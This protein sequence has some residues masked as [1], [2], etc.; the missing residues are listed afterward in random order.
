MCQRNSLHSCAVT[1]WS[2]NPTKR[3]GLPRLWGWK[4]FSWATSLF[5]LLRGRECDAHPVTPCMLR[6]S[7]DTTASQDRVSK[8]VAV[9]SWHGRK[10]EGRMFLFTV[11]ATVT[12]SSRVIVV[13]I[14]K[15]KNSLQHIHTLQGTPGQKRIIYSDIKRLHPVS[16][17]KNK[18]QQI[19]ILNTW[20][21]GSDLI[22]HWLFTF[23]SISF[24]NEITA[25]TFNLTVGWLYQRQRR[26]QRSA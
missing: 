1:I 5:L 17:V 15:K 2:Q 25:L 9:Q 14:K 4:M 22:S 6:L 19:F 21:D 13:A 12:C 7:Q 24:G 3:K 20:S 8:M 26:M 18:T 23:D 16:G 10:C 11:P